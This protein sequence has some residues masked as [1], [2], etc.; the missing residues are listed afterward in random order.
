MFEKRQLVA[1]QGNEPFGPYHR[2]SRPVEF[3][4]VHVALALE[5]ILED[6]PQV[7]I[8]GRLEK[9][10][11]P[12]VSQV[13]RK[14]LR[15]TVAQHLDRRRPLRV[16]YLLVAL[17]QCLG[18]QTLPWQRAAQEVHEHVPQRLQIIA[19]RLLPPEMRVY[20][21]VPGSAGQRFMLP[22]WYVLIRI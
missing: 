12:H 9:V 11:P 13:V 21:H 16:T 18:L 15:V 14:L 19:T 22:I 2:L 8:V 1:T 4:V 5:Q 7:V 17:L 10:Q 20:R 3:A 6:S